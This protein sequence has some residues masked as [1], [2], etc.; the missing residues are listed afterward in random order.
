MLLLLLLLVLMLM[1]LQ[2]LSVVVVV[3]SPVSSL[4]LMQCPL[5]L[6]RHPSKQILPTTE[7]MARQR[8]LQLRSLLKLTDPKT[9]ELKGV[10]KTAWMRGSGQERGWAGSLPA[11]AFAVSVCASVRVCVFE[12]EF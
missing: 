3:V 5:S 11:C 7:G 6:T 1:V 8:Q 10:R 4:I 9:Q 2:V 12:F